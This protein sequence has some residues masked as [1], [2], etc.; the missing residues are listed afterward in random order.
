MVNSTDFYNY[1][2]F[3]CRAVY[4]QPEW[5]SQCNM[6]GLQRFAEDVT[7]LL[8]STQLNPVLRQRMATGMEGKRKNHSIRQVGLGSFFKPFRGFRLSPFRARVDF[9]FSGRWCQ[10]Q[11]AGLA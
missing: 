8:S 6:A 2:L 5:L 9:P 7:P 1:C 10:P 4:K 11:S 3:A